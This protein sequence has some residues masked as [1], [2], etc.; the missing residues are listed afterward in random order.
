[1]EKEKVKNEETS[2][3]KI[4]RTLIEIVAGVGSGIFDICGGGF[5]FVSTLGLLMSLRDSKVH[6]NSLIQ[7]IVYSD[8]KDEEIPK[9]GFKS[10][11]NYI[12]G[13]TIPFAIKYHKE[14]Y[15]FIQ[16]IFN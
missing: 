12:L 2:G 10:T 7:R 13:A 5:P 11:G 8:Y 1:M 15:S 6:G 3:E 14:I 4:G 9:N 16:N